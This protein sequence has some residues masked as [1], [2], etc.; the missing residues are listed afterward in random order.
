MLASPYPND[1]G[2]MIWNFTH[3]YHYE[4]NNS[5]DRSICSLIRDFEDSNRRLASYFQRQPGHVFHAL[6]YSYG[7]FHVYKRND[8]D[9]AWTGSI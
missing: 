3:K 1:R 5:T 9:D 6:F 8:D 2:A 4:S 7:S